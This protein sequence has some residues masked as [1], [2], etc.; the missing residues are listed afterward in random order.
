MRIVID[1]SEEDFEYLNQFRD[2][3]D[4]IVK[5]KR[6][7]GG[8]NINYAVLHGTRLPKGHGDLVD[9]NTLEGHYVCSINLDG[10]CVLK[11][12]CKDCSS[13]VYQLYDDIDNIPVVVK[14]DKE[15]EE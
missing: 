11:C 3:V 7:N 14:A 15:S 13:G 6:N 12:D 1:I 4:E 5:N 9:K 10:A 8:D 2:I